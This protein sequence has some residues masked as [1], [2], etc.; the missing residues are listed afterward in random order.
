MKKIDFGS[1]EEFIKNYQKLKSS[2]K[3]GE[4]YGCTKGAVLNHAKAINYD[5]SKNKEIKLPLEKKEEIIMNYEKLKSLEKVGEIYNCSGTS[6]RNFFIKINYDYTKVEH[7]S[8]K[9]IDTETFI[10]LY[11]SLGSAQKVG[12][13]LG[14]SSTAILNHAHNIGY[15][16]ESSKNYFLTEENKKYIIDHYYDKTSGEI[17][18]ELNISRGL[19]TKTWYD[20]NLQGKKVINPKTTEVDI[21]GQKFGKWTVL[22]KTE[23]RN[24]AGVI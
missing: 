14:F 23:K 18:K 16:I 20:Y 22:Y 5:N 2:R 6:V 21:K 11:E 19:V 13:A 17:A 4:F 10:E 8:L 1:D 12:E 15:D 9:N 24:N 3:M 7:K